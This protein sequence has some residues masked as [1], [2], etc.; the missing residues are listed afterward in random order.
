MESDIPPKQMVSVLA[1]RKASEVAA[2][3]PDFIVIGADTT[4]EIG[5][6]ILNKPADIA[7]AERMLRHLRGRAHRVH[8]GVAVYRAG[9]T[10]QPKS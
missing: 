4:V 6:T 5:G 7:D 1:V 2:R 9:S 10:D 8:T 3:R